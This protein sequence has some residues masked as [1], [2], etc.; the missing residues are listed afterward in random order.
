VRYAFCGAC[1]GDE[2]KLAVPTAPSKPYLTDQYEPT[3]PKLWE[4]CLKLV[5]G[6][7]REF[8]RGERTVHAPNHGRG[9]R[10]MPNPKGMAWAVKQYNGFGGNWKGRKEAMTLEE[11]TALK[12]QLVAE[13]RAEWRVLA[14][15]G[16]AVTSTGKLEA[17][18]QQGLVER[19][20]Q[21]K[22]QDY[23]DLTPQ[24][25]KLARE[26]GHVPGVVE[27]ERKG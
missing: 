12:Q 22:R 8:T 15:G 24:G 20:R 6:E 27:N 23:W 25:L 17:L 5:N 19:V 2:S 7:K 1:E 4:Q 21:T 26:L 10:H 18:Q 14:S 9:Y 3:D 16:I 13:M 11:V